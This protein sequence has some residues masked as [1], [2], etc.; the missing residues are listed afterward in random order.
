[1]KNRYQFRYA[2]LLKSVTYVLTPPERKY[3]LPF[4]LHSLLKLFHACSLS[5]L[6]GNNNCDFLTGIEANLFTIFWLYLLLIVFLFSA[7]NTMNFRLCF[8]A[9]FFSVAAHA[10]LLPPPNVR[11]ASV[12]VIDADT[13]KLLFSR[14]PNEQ[15]PV[16]STQKL[17][18][19]LIVAE[20][21]NL[22]R[23]VTIE[24]IDETTEP[25]MLNLHAGD[26]YTRMELL[27][28]LLVKSPN[29][30]ARALARDQAGSLEGF[31]FVMNQKAAEL[32]ATSSHFV[33]PNGL[34]APDQYSTALDMSKIALAVY[35]NPI[36]RPIVATKIYPFHYA[37][38]E[39]HLLKNTNKTL[40]ENSFCNGM[41]TGYT[42]KSK[43]CLVTSGCYQGRDVITVILGTPNRDQL[44]SDSSDLLAW[45]LNAPV[46]KKVVHYVKSRSN[47]S[48]SSTPKKHH[49]RKHKKKAALSNN[50]VKSNE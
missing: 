45:A 36:L 49:Y 31:A 39:V 13:G 4:T 26:S 35:R 22:S 23:P 34:P 33:N 29:D 6:D 14:N 30:V 1:M 21:G 19:A 3:S 20:H 15:R 17:L 16:G 12:V 48:Q 9:L 18:T 38:G 24:Q 27:T 28:A 46:V 37:N 44:F 8:L 2:D 42:E 50:A 7:I 32:G 47:D 11:G 43:H 40:R 25:T 5:F 41:K 10:N